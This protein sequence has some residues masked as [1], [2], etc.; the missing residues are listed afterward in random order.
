M[1]ILDVLQVIPRISVRLLAVV[2]II[3]PSSSAINVFQDDSLSVFMAGDAAATYQQSSGFKGSDNGFLRA[4]LFH[5]FDDHWAATVGVRGYS[6]LPLPF[7]ETGALSWRD[8]A[9]QL[10]GGYLTSRY[11][12]CEYYK[13]WSTYSPLFENPIIW[14]DYGF[15]GAVSSHSGL[16]VLQGCALMNSRENGSVNGYAGIETP[17]MRAGLLCGFQTYSL[18]NQDNDLTFGLESSAQNDA[19][20]IHLAMCYVHNFGY[21]PNA[22]P[23]LVP[24]NRFDGFLE[25]RLSPFR[26]LIVDMLG[27]YRYSTLYFN[28]S[29]VFTGLDCRWFLGRIWGIGGGGER[30]D[31][32]GIITYSPGLRLFIAPAPDPSQLSIG[33]ERTWTGSSSPLYELTGNIC[34]AF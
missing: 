7:L 26:S 31:D 12:I 11:G 17:S 2:S 27:I 30:M 23:D 16:V 5:E 20:K 10:S 14:D 13:P 24:G 3:A 8:S 34:V 21:S 32:D 15:G 22:Q 1:Q 9:V 25:G 33:I 6:A 19:V 4:V 18:D 28:Q 29:E